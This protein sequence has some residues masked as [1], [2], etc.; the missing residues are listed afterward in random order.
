M[1]LPEPA[2]SVITATY[3]RAAVL[4]LTLESL[5]RS[6][7]EDWELIVVGDACTDDTEEVIR[8]FRDP[9][10]R[11]VNLPVN[12]GDQAVPN[13]EGAR[14]AR[15]RFLAFL[16]HDD[17]WTRDHLEVTA[18]ALEVSDAE[19]VTT[20][21]L[22]VD[23]DRTVRLTGACPEG[24]YEPSTWITASSWVMRRELLDRIGAWRRA[25]ELLLVPSQEWLYRAWRAG[26]RH[27][28]IARVT[29]LSL[30]SGHRRGSYVSGDIRE[31]EHYAARLRDEPAAL[32]EELLTQAALR[33]ANDAVRPSLRAPIVRLMKNLVRRGALAAG[34][35]PIAVLHAVKFGRRGGAVDALR[36]IRGLSPL[37]RLRRDE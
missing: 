20:L 15:G 12:S 22:Q 26:V 16:N 28:A 8:S 18:G 35:H 10:M 14:L 25:G 19:L 34:V 7:R 33:Q 37:P 4:R 31:L 32:L 23:A 11:F 13:N 27:R 21:T 36:R 2:I 6:S 24:H 29:N 17:F 3:N 5:S 9:R 30:P 1:T